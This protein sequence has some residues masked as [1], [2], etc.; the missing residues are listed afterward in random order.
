MLDQEDKSMSQD[1][2]SE[3]RHCQ[4]ITAGQISQ[5]GHVL[6]PAQRYQL[7]QQVQLLDETLDS[8]IAALEELARTCQFGNLTVMK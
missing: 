7:R 5:V 1:I 6:P 4:K 2:P 8:C 3:N